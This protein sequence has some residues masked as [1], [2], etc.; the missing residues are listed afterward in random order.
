MVFKPIFKCFKNEKIYCTAIIE[1]LSE[2]LSDSKTRNFTLSEYI[3]IIHHILYIE[4]D[5][6]S[7]KKKSGL[8]V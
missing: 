1:N 3:Y 6:D 7:N 8:V 5:L 2:H 4:S